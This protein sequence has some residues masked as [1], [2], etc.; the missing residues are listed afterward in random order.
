MEEIRPGGLLD[1]QLLHHLLAFVISYP[2][3]ADRHGTDDGWFQ[4]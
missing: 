2:C 3:G 1:G 4:V